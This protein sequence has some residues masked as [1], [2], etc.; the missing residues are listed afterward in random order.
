MIQ[1]AIAITKYRSNLK[2][3]ID[4][5]QTSNRFAIV[6]GFREQFTEL[7]FNMQVQTRNYIVYPVIYV[8]GFVV[9]C[10]VMVVLYVSCYR[11][12]ISTKLV[13]VPSLA[14][15]DDC[16]GGGEI[17][18]NVRY[19]CPI[20]GEL[21]KCIIIQ[22]MKIIKYQMYANEFEK[23]PFCRLLAFFRTG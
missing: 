17:P 6:I 7:P 2:Y 5:C 13:S 23:V 16:P 19:V 21:W 8:H 10:F 4:F 1:R 11:F 20:L 18:N 12:L 3:E 22:W 14:E 9:V 15:L